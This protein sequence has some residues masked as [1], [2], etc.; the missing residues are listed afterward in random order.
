MATYKI[1]SHLKIGQPESNGM[2]MSLK[3][4]DS[5][6]LIAGYENGD[7]VKFDLKMNAPLLSANMFKGQP[8]MCIDY[9]SPKR[10][11]ICGTSESTLKQFNSDLVSD[12]S[13]ELTNPGVSAI[14][15]RKSDSKLFA[16]AGWD[17]QIRLFTLKKLKPLVVLDFH[18]SPINTID[19]SPN[20]LMAAGSNDCIISFWS[21]Y[22]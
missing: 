20:N 1:V 18:K 3:A 22:A 13:V 16:S 11:G 12:L 2:L 15:I 4:I 7:L 21:L 8:V 19:F 14:T 17:S 9:S 10:V 5:D 6:K